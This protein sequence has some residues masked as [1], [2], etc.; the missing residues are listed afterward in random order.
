MHPILYHTARKC[1]FSLNAETAHEVTLAGLRLA[2]NLG[3]LAPIAGPFPED[4][5]EILGMKFPNRVGLAAGMDKEANT[6][7]AFGRLGFGFVEVGTLT[8]RPQPGNDKPRLFRLIP[9]HAII[10]RMGFNNEGIASGVEHVKKAEY[11]GKGIIGINIGK[12]KVTP[13]EEAAMDYLAC[14]RAAWPVADYI[15]VNFSSPNTPGLRELQEADSAARLLASLKSEASNLARDTGRNVPIFM[16][17]APDLEGTQI[18]ELSK[19]FLDEGLDGLIATNTTLARKGVE[20]HRWGNQAGG[21]SGAPLTQ[22]STEIIQAFAAELGGRIPI[23]GVGGIMCGQ[24]A[25][26]KI[27]A[28]ASLVQLY[29]G[30]IYNGPPLIVD[31][32]RA[33]REQCPV[34]TT[35]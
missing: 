28:G 10:N 12:N 25:V 35:P 22:R 3:V 13:N 27:K 18:A 2:E 21:L 16:K 31:C 7:D 32:V 24:D 9:H 1:L 23:I 29:S 33:M 4:P 26:D 14:L 30:F 8:P 15:A 20:E 34:T 17:V 19:V 5:V 6:V 11:K